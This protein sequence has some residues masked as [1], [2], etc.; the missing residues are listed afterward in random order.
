MAGLRLMSTILIFFLIIFQSPVC[1]GR[2]LRDNDSHGSI[3]IDYN[4]NRV[5]TTTTDDHPDTFNVL[6]YGAVGDGD[7]NS[8]DAFLKAWDDVCGASGQPTLVIPSGKVFMITPVSFT[9]PCKPPTIHIELQ[10]TIIAPGSVNTY[11]DDKRRWIQFSDVNGLTVQGGGTLDG[12]GSIWW[13]AG[14]ALS[15]HSCEDLVVKELNL[16]NSQKNHISINGCNRVDV[17]QIKITGPEDSPNTDGIDISSTSNLNIHDSVIG[18]GDDCIAINGGTSK[19]TISRLT[20]GPGHGISVGSLGKDGNYDTVEDVLVTNC[21]IKGT[22]NGA[23]IKT[24]KGGKG[25][26]RKVTFEDI[27]LVNVRNPIIIDQAYGSDRSSEDYLNMLSGSHLEISDV[28]YKGIVGSSSDERAV[29]FNCAEC[30]NIHMENVEITPVVEGKQVIA[31][32]NNTRGSSM[33]NVSP[34]V[35]CLT[36]V[37]GPVTPVTDPVTPPTPVMDPVTPPTP[38]ADPVTPPTPVADPVTGPPTPV[39][40]P[41]TPPTPVTDPVTPPTPV[42]DPVTPVTDPVTPVTDPMTPP[43]PVTNPVTPPTPVTDPLTP[44]TPVTDPLTPPTPVTD[45]VTPPTPVTDPVTGPPA[46]IVTGPVADTTPYEMIYTGAASPNPFSNFG[47]RYYAIL[48]V[49]ISWLA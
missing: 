27:V 19:V 46:D 10:G 21:T 44:P 37:K 4:A 39:T 12:Q 6:D 18:S 20:C 25:Y 24:W 15:F 48:L 16:V 8:A 41:V 3:S 5:T 14:R 47:L 40:D 26:V 32:C 42:T 23:R 49:L 31:Y 36:S 34:S 22:T 11:G 33:A 45:P 30:E 38:V 43:M 9:G 28:T 1:Y 13:D 35:P 29:S 7:T 17:S 2:S